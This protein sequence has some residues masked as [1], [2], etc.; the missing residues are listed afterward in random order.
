MSLICIAVALWA[1]FPLQAQEEPV[2]HPILASHD[3]IDGPLGGEHH[4]EDAR[5]FADGRVIYT[6]EAS[7]PTDATKTNRATYR[8]T[9]D[10]DEER[11][12]VQLLGATEIR[13]L[14][15]Q[16][17]AKTRPID[18]FW[19]KSFQ[20]ERADGNQTIHIENF[21]P[22]LN[23]QARVYPQALIELECT[24]QNLKSRA[25]KRP[26]DDTKW[27]TSLIDGRLDALK[28]PEC[29]PSES[30]P[31]VVA[32]E[33]WGSVRLGSDLT[34]VQASLG[35][36]QAG[37]KYSDS[38]FRE[39][40]KKGIE[41]LFEKAGIVRAI[42]FYNGQQD[43]EGFGRFCGQTDKGIIWQSSPEEVKKLYGQPSDDFSGQDSGGTWERLVFAGIDFRFENGKMVRIGVPGR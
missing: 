24:L 13:S 9:M 36:G 28:P 6:V 17:P 3:V 22:F 42:F 27:C 19:D 1:A 12:L 7:S 43:V 4:V 31:R 25:A 10:D 32:G 30:Q 21:Y 15:G 41:V 34:V 16:I 38:Y 18:F 26:H 2:P 39:F 5:V 29:K 8:T 33:G 11:H 20:I 35:T 14:P 40:P 37:E 23:L